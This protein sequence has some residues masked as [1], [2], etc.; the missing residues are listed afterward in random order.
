[1]E[2][3]ERQAALVVTAHQFWPEVPAEDRAAHTR[4]QRVDGAAPE[5]TAA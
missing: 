4:L 1:M 3:A 2:E 5:N